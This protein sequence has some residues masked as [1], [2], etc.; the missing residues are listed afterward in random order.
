MTDIERLEHKIVTDGIIIAE[1][2]DEILSACSVPL[3][4][5]HYVIGLNSNILKTNAQKK[6][7][8][9]HESGHCYAHAFYKKTDLLSTRR[10]AEYRADKHVAENEITKEKIESVAKTELITHICEF[11]EFFGV[12]TEYMKR[13]FFI[14]FGT[15]F[16]A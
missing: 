7:A 9:L 6:T 8:L 12:T 4:R 5:E 14:H 15:E 16:V 13:I 10:K 1:T 11:A 2:K 3:T